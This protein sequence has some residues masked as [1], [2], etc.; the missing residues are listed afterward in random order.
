MDKMCTTRLKGGRGSLGLDTEREE[1]VKSTTFHSFL[2]NHTFFHFLQIL[3]LILFPFPYFHHLQLSP[4]FEVLE[5]LRR[6]NILRILDKLRW[7]VTSRSAPHHSSV[8]RCG[9][10]S[11]S[12][13]YN[14]PLAAYIIKVKTTK[15]VPFFHLFLPFAHLGSAMEG[16]RLKKWRVCEMHPRSN[17][18]FFSKVIISL[19]NTNSSLPL[20]LFSFLL[21]KA[22]RNEATLSLS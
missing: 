10:S 15:P 16:R 11:H 7:M 20:A 12:R 18:I 1:K 19:G 3:H 8:D 17:D 2:G 21:S 14:P 6:V 9:F 4:S 22:K 5:V 13:F